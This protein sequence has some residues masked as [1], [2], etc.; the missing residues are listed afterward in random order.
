MATANEIIFDILEDVRSNHIID[1][2]DISERQIL[3]K[4]NLQRSL[5]MRNELNK[6]GRTLD[7]FT[8]QSL[9]CVELEEANSSECPSLPVGCSVLRTKCDLP[10]TIELH[11]RTAITKVGPI[12]KLDYFFSFVPYQQAAFSGNGKYNK[13]SIYA[14]IYNRKMY[15][16]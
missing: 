15:F 3:Y 16:K 12:D 11:N 7:P 10:K 6:P 1:D 13:D 14:F 8:V 4:I 5:L 2:L 9:G